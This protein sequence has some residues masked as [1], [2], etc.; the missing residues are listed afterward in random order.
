ML[1]LQEKID[2]ILLE[3]AE[4]EVNLSSAAARKM[5]A[6]KIVSE[7]F[8]GIS[9][10]KKDRDDLKEAYPWLGWPDLS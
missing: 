6:D 4:N 9:E 2:K 8:K 1:L 3:F 5:V 7:C 10:M